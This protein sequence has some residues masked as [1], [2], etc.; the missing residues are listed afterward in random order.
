[1]CGISEQV[2][3]QLGIEHQLGIKQYKSSVYN[4]EP[5]GTVERFHRH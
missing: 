3:H 2:M 4:P 5:Q 1:M